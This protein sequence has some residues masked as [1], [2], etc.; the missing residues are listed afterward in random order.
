MSHPAKTYLISG[1]TDCFCRV[2]F[3]Y[4][5]GWLIL[6]WFLT[7]GFSAGKKPSANNEEGRF[8]IYIDG[9]E[10][11]EEKYS[12]QGSPNSYHSESVIAFKTPGSVSQDV[13]IET[14]LNMDENYMPQSYRVRSNIGGKIGEIEGAFV[15][16]QATFKYQVNGTP[17]QNGLLLDDYYVVL[18]A[19]VF[20]HFIF[21]G[22][23]VELDNSI[24]SLDVVIPQ[25]TDN[26]VLKIQNSGL[27]KIELRGKKRELH[28]LKVDSGKLLIDLWIDDHRLLYKIALPVKNI[29]IIRKP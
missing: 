16:G 19:N 15:P 12:I 4:A 7:Y 22:R 17:H 8:G 9:N 28:H 5:L 20:H 6:P 13:K 26:G 25:E 29:E 10:I 1:M 2:F 21:V 23:L 18:D 3:R 14:Q 24:Q 11:G 27:E